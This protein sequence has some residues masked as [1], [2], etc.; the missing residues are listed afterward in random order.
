MS[1]VHIAPKCDTASSNTPATREVD[2]VNGSRHNKNANRQADAQ[3]FLLLLERKICSGP[4]EASNIRCWFIPKLQSSKMVFG[5]AL[6]LATC[7]LSR[8]VQKMNSYQTLNSKLNRDEPLKAI[9]VI[10]FL[11]FFFCS[12]INRYHISWLS[13]FACYCFKSCCCFLTH[14]RS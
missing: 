7:A 14:F 13:L 5:P 1:R 3:R 9:N 4:P 12:W 2:W 11:F 8:N 10:D 6:I